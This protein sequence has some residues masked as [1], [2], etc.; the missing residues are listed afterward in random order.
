MTLLTN[1]IAPVSLT[2]GR[3]IVNNGHLFV[4]Y[5]DAVFT[6]FSIQ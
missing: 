4:T 1:V 2:A 3:T 6:L 5:N